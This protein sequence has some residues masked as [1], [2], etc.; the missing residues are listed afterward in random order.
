MGDSLIP[1]NASTFDEVIAI[2]DN[3]RESAF[4]AVNR[5]LINMYWDIGEY[6]SHRVTDGGWGK[7]V[8]KE[9]SDFIQSRYV[10][11]KGFSSSNIWRMKQFYETY[12]GNEKLATLLRELTWSHNLQILSCKTDEEREFYLTLSVRNRYSF[13][14]L[15][16]Q[17]DS[18]L[19]ERTMMSE[20]TNKLIT[21]R[22]EGLT[23]LRDSYVLEFLDLPESHK[24]KDLRKAIVFNLKDFILEFGKDFT[25][26]GEEYRV[27]VGNRDFFI[28][29]LFYN[30][31]LHCLVAI[32]LKIGEFEPEHLGKM[33]FYLEALDRDIK[34]S[35]ENPSVG[36]ILC[37]KKDAMVVEYALSRSMS[38]AMIADYKLHLPDKHILEN[39]LRELTE[40][41][42]STADEDDE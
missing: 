21:E 6:V 41:A 2:I 3:A 27:Q 26:V 40:L 34:K 32:E 12:C 1:N 18:G 7:S 39:K 16:R 25:F 24:E 23:A 5:E 11:I 4:R 20:I 36:L 29:L 28:D 31:E 22:S 33:E 14:E 17:M 35:D 30:R 9:F 42:E 8:V 13:R 10:G 38:P 19:Y 15:K 37:T